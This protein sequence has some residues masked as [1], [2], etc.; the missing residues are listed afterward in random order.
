MIQQMTKAFYFSKQY[1]EKKFKEYKQV[2]AKQDVDFDEA[3]LNAIES[4]K[5]R[6]K[7]IKIVK[8]SSRK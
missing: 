6:G 3:A 7:K 4:V 1:A 5:D 8:K 2:E